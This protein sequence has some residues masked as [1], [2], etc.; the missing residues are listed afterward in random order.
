LT[1]RLQ[2]EFLETL[3]AIDDAAT[4]DPKI[5]TKPTRN[6]TEILQIQCTKT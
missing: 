5:L 3:A 1:S 4:R 6:L 2:L